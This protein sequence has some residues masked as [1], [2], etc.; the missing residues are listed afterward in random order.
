MSTYPKIDEIK[1]SAGIFFDGLND[2]EASLE[3]DGIHCKLAKKNT[4]VPAST[5]S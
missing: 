4:N 3:A 5:V 2:A 1:F